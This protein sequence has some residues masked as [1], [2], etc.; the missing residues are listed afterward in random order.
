MDKWQTYNSW[1]DRVCAYIE[2]VGPIVNAP[3]SAMQS[4]PVLDKSPEVVFLGHDAREPDN[5]YGADKNR[6]FKG[7]PDF[8]PNRHTWIMWSRLEHAFRKN[9][10]DKLVT[11]GNFMLMNL[12]FFGADNIVSSHKKMKAEVMKQCINFTEELI[13][14]IIKPKFVVCFSVNNIFDCLKTRMKNVEQKRLSVPSKIKIGVWNG[15]PVIGIS[16]PSARNLSTAY[17]SEISE[18]IKEHF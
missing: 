5:F 10:L 7:N 3:S 9:G 6:F 12:F 11:D 16:H 2:E 15:I 17:W 13:C 8:I 14:D 18:Y 4:A 1:V